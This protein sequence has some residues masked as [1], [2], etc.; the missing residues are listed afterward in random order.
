MTILIHGSAAY[1]SGMINIGDTL[2]EANGVEF[3]DLTQKEAVDIIKRLPQGTVHLVLLNKHYSSLMSC[4]MCVSPNR[5][6]L[7]NAELRI[8]CMT[9]NI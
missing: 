3:E 9:Q 8:S 6:E 7:I 1:K 5:Y 2:L 4:D